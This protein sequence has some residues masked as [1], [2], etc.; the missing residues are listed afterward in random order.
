MAKFFIFTLLV[1][2]SQNI[3]AKDEFRTWQ[4]RDYSVSRENVV[5]GDK[6]VITKKTLPVFEI[7]NA[8]QPDSVVVPE[9]TIHTWENKALVIIRNYSGGAHCCY[10]TIVFELGD[11]FS[12]VA[13]FFFNVSIS[14]SNNC[15]E[16]SCSIRL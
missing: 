8:A 14:Y 3:Y 5:N 4:F 6:I 7:I 13:R 11:K 2:L 1:L 16:F 12:E 10:D 15:L 9:L